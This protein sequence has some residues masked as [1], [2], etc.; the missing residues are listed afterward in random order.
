MYVKWRV[1]GCL[2]GNKAAF[3][4]DDNWTFQQTVIRRGFCG[5]DEAGAG[6]DFR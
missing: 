6:W 1:M 4:K 2:R 5:R 3:G